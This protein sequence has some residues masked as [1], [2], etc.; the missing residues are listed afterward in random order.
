M[1]FCIRRVP[2]GRLTSELFIHV[3]EGNDVVVRGP[4]GEMALSNPSKRDVAF[5]STGTDVAPFRGMIQ[6]FFETGQDASRGTDR[7]A[8]PD[9]SRPP[10]PVRL[11]NQRDGRDPRPDRTI[12]GRPGE[13]HGL[14]GV[15]VGLTLR[16]RPL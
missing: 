9:R 2:G 3:E 12:R 13:A 5:L 4:Y 15:R 16:G 1:E 6:H 14:R 10:E 8:G 11:R 7:V